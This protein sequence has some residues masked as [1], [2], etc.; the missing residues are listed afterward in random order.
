[1]LNLKRKLPNLLAAILC[2]GFFIGVDQFALAAEQKTQ[3]E[4]RGKG[5]TPEAV[6]RFSGVVQARSAK[7]AAVPLNIALKEWTVTRSAEPQEIPEQGFYIVQLISGAATTEIDGKSIP[8]HTGDFWVVQ[9]GQ[10]MTVSL[11]RPQESVMLRTITI[12]SGH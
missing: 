9:K 10:R 1:M 12:S 8:H 6:T 3:L 5:A 4:P 2:C 7:G 11:R